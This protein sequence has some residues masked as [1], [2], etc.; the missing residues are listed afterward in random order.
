[1]PESASHSDR[2]PVVIIG[3]GQAGLAVAY[4]LER[5]GLAPA[6]D[7]IVLDRDPDA[8]GAWQHRWP[9]LRLDDAHRV[10]D[11][12]GMRRDLGLSFETAPGDRPAGEVVSDYYRRYERFH[13]LH[14][15]HRHEV[16][17][18]TRLETSAT[19]AGEHA[20]YRLTVRAPQG[21]YALLADVVV[22]ASGTWGAPNIPYVPGIERFSGRQLHTQQYRSAAEFAGSRVAIVGGGTS[23]IGFVVELHDVA[24]SVHWFTRRPV[25]FIDEPSLTMSGGRA[26]VAAQD[27]AARAGRPLP[28]IVS[29]TDVPVTANMRALYQRGQLVPQPMFVR[30]DAAGAVLADGSHLDLDVI[31]WA[32]GFR[33]D[34]AHLRPLRLQ[35]PS[36]GIAVADGAAL[37][38]ARILLAGYG[39]QA[40]TISSARGARAVARHVIDLLADDGFPVGMHDDMPSD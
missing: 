24:R 17:A 8:G 36:G 35:E 13:H 32:T 16:T 3:A 2:V 18:V 22:N 20:R 21:Q 38:D 19:A 7:F 39:P 25:R 23:A 4:H 33:P 14:V 5:A 40:S 15:R 9:S 27:A 28:S 11:L 1:M 37:R 12:P 30:L 6:I 26:S 29:T 31:I 10:G 34:V